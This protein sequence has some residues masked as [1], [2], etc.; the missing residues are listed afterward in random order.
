METESTTGLFERVLK[1]TWR[2]IGGFYSQFLY[3]WHLVEVASV[4]Y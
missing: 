1:A 2:Q 4:G 3:K